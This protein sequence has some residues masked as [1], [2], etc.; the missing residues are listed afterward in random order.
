MKLGASLPLLP[1]E[2]PIGV[3]AAGRRGAPPT[4]SAAPASEGFLQP[5]QLLT[6]DSGSEIHEQ[7]ESSSKRSESSKENASISAPPPPP[8]AAAAAATGSMFSPPLPPLFQFMTG[9]A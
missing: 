6:T 3:S 9:D 4:G 1:P 2:G 7:T 5:R 8:A